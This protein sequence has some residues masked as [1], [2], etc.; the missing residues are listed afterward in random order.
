MD[1]DEIKEIQQNEIEALK[2]IF[3]DDYEEVINKTAWKVSQTAPEFLLHLYPLGVDA[4][5][6]YVKIDL[7]VRFPKTYPN[8]P[9]EM[10]LINPVGLF[11]KTI[12]QLNESM[13][14]A[15][16]EMTGREMMYDIADHVR[17]FLANYNSPPPEGSKLT[18]HEQM[19]KRMENDLKVEK[20]REL[21]E[22]RDRAEQ[23]E[24][25]LRVQSEMMNAKIQEELERKREHARV[26]RQHRHEF[27]EP[28]VDDDFHSHF[29]IEE[30][31]E[32][33]KVRDVVS[34]EIKTVLFDNPMTI[35]IEEN[36]ATTFPKRVCFH[37]VA[38]GPCVGKGTI[39][40]VYSAQP[41]GYKVI[42]DNG[43]VDDGDGADFP[44]LLALKRIDVSGE[45]YVTQAGKRKLQEIEREL[46]RLRS[47]Q[48]PNISCI[49]NAR[50]ERSESD[51]SSWALYV[52]M[53][54]EQ[55]GS[56]YDLI[57]KCG[58]GL[59]L[60]IV[61]KYMKQLLWAVNHIHLNGFVCKDIRSKSVFCTNDQILKLADVS[62]AKRLHDL[63]KSNPLVENDR[64][65]SNEPL[66]AWISPE[67]RDR[68]GVYG[69]KNDIWC[70]GIIFLEMLWGVDVTRE[71]GDFA[72]FLR[73]VSGEFPAQ[74]REF[75][76]KMLENDPKKRLTAIDLLNDPFFSSE[77][78]SLIADAN[79]P[80]F[81]DS[82]A[83][84]VQ[85]KEAPTLGPTSHFGFEPSMAPPNDFTRPTY[86]PTANMSSMA[87]ASV[88]SGTSRYKADFEEIEFLGKGGF[89]EVV[90]ARNKLDG[91]L[92][93]IKKI[94]L[95]PRDSEDIR[96]ILRE[97]QTLSSLHHQYV[98]R[99]YT[100]WFEDE[101][102]TG[103]KDSDD[104]DYSEDE[105]E[106]DYDEEDEDVS[107]LQKRFDFLSMNHSKSHSYS[108][109]RFDEDD[110]VAS[111]EDSD[112][113]FDTET[114][115]SSE[116]FISFVQ[117]DTASDSTDATKKQK[118]ARKVLAKM[119]KQHH[120]DKSSAS[121]R[122]SQ[123]RT[124]VL[125]IQMEYCEKKTLRDVIDEGI[126]ED[127]AW[128]LFRQ[129]LEGLV[130]IHSQGMIHRDLKPSNIFLDSNNDVKIGD[131][132]LATTNQTL[133]DAV[134][135][136]TKTSTVGRL[137]Y[138][139][140][141]PESG[142]NSF[143]GY[144]AT[145]IN[146]T[147][148][149]SMT[150][151]V[152]TTFYVSP[153]V[154]PDPTTGATSGM[155]YN[156]KVDMFSLGVMFFEMCYKFQTGMQ[157]AIILTELRNGKFPDDFPKEY[158]NQKKIILMLL[159]PQ[160]KDRPNSFELLRSDLLPPKLEDEYIKE[161]VRTIANPNTPYY[162]KLMSAM[163]SQS[164]D[165]HKDFTYDYQTQVEMPFDPFNHI[166]H[167]RIQEHMAKVFRRHGAINVSVPLLIPKNDLYEWNWKNPVYLMDSHG[168]LNQLPFDQTVPF[169]RYISRKKG[170]PELKRFTFEKV[171]RENPSGGQ[172]ETV[173][174]ADFDI[175]HRDTTPMVPDAEVIKVVEEV[176]EELPPYRKGGF[177]FIINHA[178]ITDLILDNCRV[179]T[180]YRKGVL[181]ALSSLGRGTS[182]STV[183]NVL[184][185][186]FHLQRS[187]LDELSIF[188]IQGELEV[189]SKKVENLLVGP[190]K[191][192]FREYVHDLRLLF[193]MCRR[194]GVHHKVLF[195]P[196][197][198]YNNHFYKNGMV[199]ET[200]ADTI[201]SKKKDVLAVGGR[202]DILIQHFAHP[203]ASANRKLRA[204]GVNIAVQKLI[205]HLDMHQ[206]EQV[207]YLVK[208]KN[209]RLRSFGVWA[210]KKSDVYVASFGKVLIQERLEIVRE[211]W[212]HGIRADFQYN[213]GNT[214]TPEELVTYCKK[215]SI[216]WIV[217]VKYKNP[218]GKSSG[219]NGDSSTT[220]KVKDV[221]RKTE[222][223]ISK[224]D[225]CIW[226]TAEI[227]EQMRV[228]HSHSSKIRNKHELKTKE[229][230]E[231]T[232]H[233]YLMHEVS[234]GEGSELK[235]SN[236]DVQVVYSEA[237]GKERMKM[238]HKHKSM[239]TD[240]AIHHLTPIMDSLKR[241][242]VQVIA[243]DLPKE[244]IKKMN[245][246]NFWQDDGLKKL[247]DLATINQ[248]DT[249]LKA[250]QAVE[251]LIEA[252]HRCVWLY[253]HK[254]DF[255]MLCNLY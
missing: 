145:S 247:M 80:I 102:G 183:R 238:K 228:D 253:S 209:E 142:V 101:D 10:H 94:R 178:G 76:Q 229:A 75:A 100:T 62:Y 231:A 168:S 110:D 184:K 7:K 79:P 99:Y 192:R 11:P 74:A 176:L 239:L 51:R 237:R 32:D 163:F 255:A 175:V 33:S 19:V 220:V 93:A 68:P 39:G 233:D 213:D 90:K 58:G 5:E 167:D 181:V 170:F 24:A 36:F 174:E 1:L 197:L 244:L 41:I 159:S 185:L 134:N 56:L 120:E 21:Q 67:V 17:T 60:A 186:K 126:N 40:E 152:G 195:H 85:P 149:E 59:R 27:G 107:V 245:E 112:S 6:A 13:L 172:P 165:R 53:D 234:K 193:T 243:F 190:H 230:S 55:G 31:T 95:D 109:V 147:A 235:K 122:R 18:L 132:G 4:S 137:Q 66:A 52:L 125:Y 118:L 48:H 242:E 226:L 63:H 98:V 182:F 194:I 70:L 191:S 248:R 108:A 179:P 92:Y 111:T 2:A 144:S 240:K 15:A 177:H 77:G 106:S 69:R 116:D 43:P 57:R 207:K 115:A 202:Y 38:L 28:I 82:V 37:A 124:R 47:L 138:A 206:S 189:V 129:V 72:A 252:K 200:V 96:K 225:L 103:W 158:V 217:I 105:S 162:N 71:F 97:V 203:S 46:D 236:F 204:V 133:V 30:D 61:R 87:M 44:C 20:E 140:S 148:D 65:M 117:D 81:T 136:F 35:P 83:P 49:Y 3:M 218:E 9:P 143:N 104:D 73:S 212:S 166:F 139:G 187:V 246:Y 241:D 216:N 211:L 26:A 156:Q 113:C 249:L 114:V 25:E 64:G 50:L 171:Y 222:H 223:E 8:K 219:Q 169:A 180:D 16:R 151:G 42:S 128:R 88:G 29:G 91:R 14:S 214:L 188:N 131:F 210:P 89:G 227:G 150:T 251:K 34:S 164:S 121:E 84:A 201:D 157:R 160:P 23:E 127:E 221:L 54:Y 155:R 173:L 146:F 154:L 86:T 45:Y 161:C 78:G 199:F 215:A 254:D 153:E 119:K 232:R 205:R 123:H 208:A 135:A 250:K 22:Q 12:Q 130:H 224:A 198:V 196:L 141:A